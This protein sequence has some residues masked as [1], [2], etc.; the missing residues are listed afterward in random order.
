VVARIEGFACWRV[1]P[2]ACAIGLSGAPRLP[3]PWGW[4]TPGYKKII[5][6][7]IG[8]LRRESFVSGAF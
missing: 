1:E 3:R 4:I 6:I 2:D 7:R 8:L 5:Q